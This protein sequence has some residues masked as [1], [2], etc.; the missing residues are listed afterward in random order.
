MNSRRAAFHGS[1]QT[2]SCIA[3]LLSKIHNIF[4][5]NTQ[6]PLLCTASRARVISYGTFMANAVCYGR[7]SRGN[8]ESKGAPRLFF[9]ARQSVDDPMW[10]LQR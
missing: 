3:S 2:A 5:L 6:G 1:W 10:A 9:P 4:L 8:G 7:I